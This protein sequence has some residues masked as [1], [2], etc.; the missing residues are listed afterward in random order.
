MFRSSYSS[1]YFP[2]RILS[3]LDQYTII[4]ILNQETG[5]EHLAHRCTETARQVVGC[6]SDSLLVPFM[7]LILKAMLLRR[8]AQGFAA[9]A[10]PVDEVGRVLE[11]REQLCLFLKKK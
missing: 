11:P 9:A 10:F 2:A 5:S 1:L 8:K 4:L 6:P 7:R 3:N